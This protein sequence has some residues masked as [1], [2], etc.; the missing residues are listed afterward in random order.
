MIRVVHPGSRIRMLTFYAFRIPDPEVK[1][2]Q[3]P[4][5]QHWKK[6]KNF[7][8]KTVPFRFTFLRLFLALAPFV[9]TRQVEQRD[10]LRGTAARCTL[11]GFA[12][13]AASCV[14]RASSTISSPRI[15]DN[16]C[17]FWTVFRIHT[18]LSFLNQCNM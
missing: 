9:W 6:L 15:I 5:P 18:G 11:L 7:Y 13:M 14:A 8:Q 3:I 10:V 1:K 2:A 16:K 4:D 12:K 17:L